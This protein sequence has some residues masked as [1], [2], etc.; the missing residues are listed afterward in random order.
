MLLIGSIIAL[1]AA[2]YV[3]TIRYDPSYV[4][5]IRNFVNPP[6]KTVKN[7]YWAVCDGDF[8]TANEH[9]SASI[10][11]H[12]DVMRLG[13]TSFLTQCKN[14]G[15]LADIRISKE[16]IN[17]ETAGVFGS[18]IFKN[19]TSEPFSMKLYLEKEKWKIAWSPQEFDRGLEKSLR[20]IR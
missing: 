12:K 18:A 10:P 15:G 7:F 17:D 1:L 3:S 9:L 11:L 20:E 16:T 19:D 8:E 14:K 5:G 6:S 13:L 4:R 2:P